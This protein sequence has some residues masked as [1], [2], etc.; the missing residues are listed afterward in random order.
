M[1]ITKPKH[2]ARRSRARP[3]AGEWEKR[4]VGRL[5]VVGAHTNATDGLAAPLGGALGVAGTEGGLVGGW[6]ADKGAVLLAG[7][8]VLQ[9]AGGLGG[10]TLGD[11]GRADYSESAGRG[12]DGTLDSGDG[13]VDLVAL[14]GSIEGIAVVGRGA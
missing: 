7:A 2:C 8:G 14:A 1:P 10:D 5:A 13:D 4:P 6:R 9:G 3:R 11:V 12:A